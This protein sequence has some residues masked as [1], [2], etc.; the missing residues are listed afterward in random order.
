MT[1]ILQIKPA[2]EDSIIGFDASEAEW[3]NGR[4]YLKELQGKLN[5]NNCT[6]NCPLSKILQIQSYNEFKKLID[7]T[8][9]P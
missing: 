7:K 1:E 8:I 2:C 5:C 4:N 3:E 6:L 9:L